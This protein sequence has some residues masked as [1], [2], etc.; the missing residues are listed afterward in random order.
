MPEGDYYLIIHQKFNGKCPQCK[1]S[2]PADTFKLQETMQFGCK[3]N[4]KFIYANPAAGAVRRGYGTTR[5]E[6]N[7]WKK[8]SLWDKLTH[9]EA[10]GNVEM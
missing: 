5:H 6:P 4:P 8:P 1:H 10:N 7:Q 3:G 9:K 2:L